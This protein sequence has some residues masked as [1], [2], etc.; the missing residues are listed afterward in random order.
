MQNVQKNITVTNEDG[1]EE[2]I[3][4][5]NHEAILVLLMDD[6]PE[7]PFGFGMD[8]VEAMYWAAEVLFGVR[9]E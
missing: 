8:L 2:V 9:D 6:F 4:L 1:T 5:S 7:L 3:E